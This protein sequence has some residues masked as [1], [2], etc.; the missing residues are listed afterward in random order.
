MSCVAFS[1][2]LGNVWR[3]PYTAY[4]N[5]GGAFIIPYIVVLIIIGK[6]FY[7]MEMILGQFTSRSCVQ[8]WSVSPAFQGIGYGV[9]VSV[10]SVITYYCA[11]M[12]LTL[13]YMVASFQSV[14]PWAYCWHEWEGC[15]DSSTGSGASGNGSISSAEFYFRNFVLNERGIEDGLGLPSWKLVLALLVSWVFVYVVICK[16]VKSTGKAAYFLALFPYVV[17]IS[18]LIRA[19]T[20]EGAGEGIKFLFEPQWHKILDPEVWYAAVTQSFFSLGVCFGAVTMYSS[21]N[22]FEHNVSRD[23]L[24]VTSL[25]LIT[26]L[27][28]ATTIF[29]ILGN[30]A[31]TSGND[32]EQVVRGGT[33]LAFVSYPE[34]LA[35]FDVVPQL[36]AVLFFLMLFVLGIGTTVAFCNVI[37][38]IIKDQFPHI[39]Q[40]KIA[41]GLSI[42]AFLVGVVYCTPGG[43]YILNLVDYFGGT[44]IIVFLASFEVVAVAWVYGVDNFMDDVEFMVGHRPSL[45]WRFCWCYL[46][47]LSLF[48]I[49]IYF[50][51]NMTPLTYN[52]EYYPI[53]AYAAGWTLLALGVIPFPLGIIVVGIR[54]RDKACTNIFKPSADWGPKD[55]KKYNEWRDFK[56]SK[57]I[58]RACANKSKVIAA[59][60]GK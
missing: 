10:F 6:P 24:I 34:A 27:I 1:V 39:K 21:Y 43:Q 49:L 18:L 31:H 9:T 60:F 30:L 14:L 3:F 40:W 12:A 11:L 16:G 48:T 42:F 2:G 33:G 59:L 53:S 5:G 8:I 20:L 41:A 46:T 56:Q 7:Y 26:S 19:V 35:K 37:I 51:I 32:I 47:P 45:Y 38:S 25:D 57:R 36:F 15:F 55:P 52:D 54:N 28:A 17:M 4:Q 13:F 22:N 29:G 44:F 23:C 50:L 58:S